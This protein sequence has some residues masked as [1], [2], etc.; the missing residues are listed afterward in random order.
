MT[1]A[2]IAITATK[3]SVEHRAVTDNLHLRLFLDQLG[4]GARGQIQQVEVAR[5]SAAGDG[6]K[7]EREEGTC[8]DRPLAVERGI[9]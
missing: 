4:R 5:Q 2:I 7:D 3:D 8:E 6:D 9:L 1:A